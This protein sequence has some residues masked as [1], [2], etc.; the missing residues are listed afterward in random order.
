VRI[1]A[2][3]HRGRILKA[4]KGLGTRPM[5]DRVREALFSSLGPR[6]DGARVLDLFAGT[7]SLGLESLSRGAATARLVESDRSALAALR[8]NVALLRLEERA[9]VVAGD[10]LDPSAWGEAARYDLVFFD[11]PYPLLAAQHTR[12]RLLAVLGTLLD[13]RL[14]PGGCLVFHTP[15][16]GFQASELVPTPPHRL[17][18]Y[19]TNA[20][21]TLEA[22]GAEAG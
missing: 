11:P 6:V 9:D 16:G 15:R 2:G 5:L 19:G 18:E 17:R 1:I 20:L 13:E 8:S 22:R 10:A 21:W 12:A 3:E 14:E 4:P 7:G